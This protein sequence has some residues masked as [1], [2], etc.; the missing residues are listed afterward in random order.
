[1]QL[2]HSFFIG[3]QDVGVNN[4]ITNKALLEAFTNIT[5][6]REIWSGRVQMTKQPTIFPGLC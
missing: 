4:E 3:I 2:E 6:L 5:N 1:M